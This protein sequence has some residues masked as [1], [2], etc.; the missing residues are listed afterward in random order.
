MPLTLVFYDGVC[1][2]CD[3][4]VQFILRRDTKARFRFAP[5]QGALAQRMLTERGRDPRRLDTVYVVAGWQSPGE[6]VFERSRAVLHAIGELGGGWS[7]AA[8]AAKAIPRPIA[9]AVYA[10]VARLRY[11][12]F[13]RYAACPL[14]RPEWRSRFIE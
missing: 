7:A 3:R 5:L 9:D 12:V 13:G 4:F 11:R 14:P 6:R 8:R 2:L 1:G 10:L